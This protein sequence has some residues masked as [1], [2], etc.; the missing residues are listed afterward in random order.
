MKERHCFFCGSSLNWL[1]FRRINFNLSLSYLKKV[2]NHPSIEL[3]CCKC[4]K[5]EAQKEKMLK[6]LTQDKFQKE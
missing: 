5:R 1:D 2:W 6:N 4:F 3:Y